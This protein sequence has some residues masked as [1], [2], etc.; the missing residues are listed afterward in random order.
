[1]TLYSIKLINSQDNRNVCLFVSSDK[2]VKIE[3]EKVYRLQVFE[4]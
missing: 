1:M 3:N 4:K 2:M